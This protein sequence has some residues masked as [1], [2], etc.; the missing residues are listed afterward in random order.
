M[1]HEEKC[2]QSNDNAHVLSPRGEEGLFLPRD[3]VGLVLCGFHHILV[4][5]LFLLLLE[6]VHFPS[7]NRKKKLPI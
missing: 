6:V 4:P 5:G 1:Y 3:G 2:D 7:K